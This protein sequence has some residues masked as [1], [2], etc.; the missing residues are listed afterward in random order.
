MANTAVFGIYPTREQVASAV[1]RRKNGGFRS[2]DIS[3]LWPHSVAGKHLALKM[4]AKTLQG[5]AK[6]G[7]AAIIIGGGL[8][9]LAGIGFLAMPALRPL[10]AAGRT[11][12]ALLSGAGIGAVIGGLIGALIGGGVSEHKG[13]RRHQGPNRK[14]DIL[15]S[16]H[17]DDA[18]G[19]RKAKAASAQ[20]GA[21]DIGI[22][23]ESKADYGNTD[24]PGVRQAG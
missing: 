22:S 13:K 2:A 17:S 8:G 10:L 14:N 16:L 20:T 12:P 19:A 15:P 6:G 9:W 24:R 23:A 11:L 7:V 18:G 1:D 3:L 4:N 5:A 21:G